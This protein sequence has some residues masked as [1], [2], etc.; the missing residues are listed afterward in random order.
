[1]NY[2]TFKDSESRLEEQL[3]ILDE[4]EKDEKELRKWKRQGGEQNERA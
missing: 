1:M 4:L 2:K 3:K